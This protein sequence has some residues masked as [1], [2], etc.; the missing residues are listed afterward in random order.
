MLRRG[1]A[2]AAPALPVPHHHGS[3]R[4]REGVVFALVP[5][6]TLPEGRRG[7]RVLRLAQPLYRR[8]GLQFSGRTRGSPAVRALLEV[9]GAGH[10]YTEAAGKARTAAI[11]AA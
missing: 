8:F 6:P 3:Q 5:E 4:V 11:A 1:T 2:S 7:L 10:P 9:A